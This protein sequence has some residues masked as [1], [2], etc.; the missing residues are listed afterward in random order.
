MQRIQY[1]KGLSFVGL[2][3]AIPPNLA[4]RAR[5]SHSEAFG[6]GLPVHAGASSVL[7]MSSSGWSN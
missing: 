7:M 3:R 6:G 4:G 2:A 5:R 1:Q